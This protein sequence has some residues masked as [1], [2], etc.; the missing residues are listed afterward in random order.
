MQRNTTLNP[1]HEPYTAANRTACCGLC[2][3]HPN[4][5]AWTYHPPK[6]Q[7]Y[8]TAD[9]QPHASK[10]EKAV[11]GYK[12]SLPPTP[13]APSRHPTPPPAPTP[14]PTPAPPTPIPDPPMGYFP[15]FVFLLT[16]DQVSFIVYLRV[17]FYVAYSRPKTTWFLPAADFLLTGR[18]S[19]RDG[20]DA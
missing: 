14:P 19:G 11:S 17:F 9:V 15:N 3:Q 16:D 5:T 18:S 1:N 12:G 2:T 6:E 7:C 10:G 4:C 20:A 13:A 8:I